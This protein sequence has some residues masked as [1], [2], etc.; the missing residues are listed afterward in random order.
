MIPRRGN[1]P[2]G[3][4]V[5]LVL[6]HLVRAIRARWPKVEIMIRGDS[7]YGRPEAPQ[8]DLNHLCTAQLRV[9]ASLA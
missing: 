1:T 6:R 3:A 9:T 5:V 4:E 7:P 2:D 8:D